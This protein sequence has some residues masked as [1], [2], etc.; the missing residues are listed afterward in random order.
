MIVQSIVQL[1]ASCV[2]SFTQEEMLTKFNHYAII[3]IMKDALKKT[4]KS[5]DGE[6][7]KWSSAENHTPLPL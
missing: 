3:R 6:K 5:G 4:S 1:F 2:T 7:R